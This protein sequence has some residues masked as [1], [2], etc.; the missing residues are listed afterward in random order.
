MEHKDDDIGS[1]DEDSLVLNNDCSSER[2]S[3]ELNIEYDEDN[4]DTRSEL[5]FDKACETEEESEK[6]ALI[7]EK[8]GDKNITLQTW[9]NLAISRY[10][11]VADDLRCQVW[12][13][14]LGVDPSKDEIIPSLEELSS[15]SEYQQ[16]V[17]DVNRSLKRF[18][19]GELYSI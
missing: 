17:L 15:H 19:P 11:L 9:Q 2:R 14:L 10:G 16:V 8:L 1:L 13:L 3:D 12:P 7:E 5:K 4:E 6:R 18:P